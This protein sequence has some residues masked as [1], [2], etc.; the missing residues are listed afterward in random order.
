M[1]FIVGLPTSEMCNWV[2]LV[3]DRYSKY[4][5]FIFAPKECFV[6]QVS[7]LL[8]KHV[9]RYWGLPRSIVSDQDTRFTGLFWTELF[10]LIGFGLNFSTSFHPQSDRQTERI[11]DLLELYLR[12]YVCAN[13]KD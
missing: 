8:F 10:N 2:L 6:E 9:V 13:Q 3:V 11:N 7:H 1:G 5:A 12:H 4:A